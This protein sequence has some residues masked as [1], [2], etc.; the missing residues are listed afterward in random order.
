VNVRVLG[1]C[2]S[3]VPGQQTSCLL[4]NEQVIV[5]AGGITEKLSVEEQAVIDHILISHAHLEHVYDLAFLADNVMARR[6]SPLRVWA[7]EKVLDV[8]HKN[9]LLTRSGQ[10]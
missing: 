8:L 4:I 10:T 9:L 7:P 5:D 2:G 3:L 1:S 6:N